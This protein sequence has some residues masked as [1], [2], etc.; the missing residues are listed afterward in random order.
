[1]ANKNYAIVFERGEQ[2]KEKGYS[3]RVLDYV[4][5]EEKILKGGKKV[6]IIDPNFKEKYIGVD[7]EKDPS[8]E[9]LFQDGRI[10]FMEDKN[11]LVSKYVYGS[12]V[13]MELFHEIIN[14]N[15]SMY[16]AGYE[17]DENDSK[18]TTEE[19]KDEYVEALKNYDFYQGV[20]STGR[21]K[22]Y[23]VRKEALNVFAKMD[24]VIGP[25][26]FDE[27]GM[28]IPEECQ[29]E[30]YKKIFKKLPESIDMKKI[31]DECRKYIIGQDEHILPVLCAIDDNLSATIPEEKTNVLV[32]GATGVGK[33]AVFKRIAEMV[34][35]PIVIENSTQFTKAGYVGRN[36][37]DIFEDLLQ[38]AGNDIELAQRG[39]IIIDEIDKKASGKDDRVSGIGVIHSMLKLLEGGQYTYETG[40]GSLSELKTFNTL[41][42]TIAFGGAFSGLAEQCVEKNI[43]FGKINSHKPSS[44]DIYSIDNLEKYGIPPE[45]VGRIQLIELFNTLGLEDLKKIMLE[46]LINPYNLFVEKMKRYATVVKSDESFIDAVAKEAYKRKTGARGLYSVMKDATKRAEGEIRLMPKYKKELILTPECVEDNSAYTLKRVYRKGTTK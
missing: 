4:E 10:M 44:I 32:G 18:K 15:N 30:N 12:P 42:T 26:V 11:S 31:Y 28:E 46:A 40:K 41:K 6:F 22:T 36:I 16:M 34:G 13:D 33:T 45:F 7:I 25:I 38:A 27:L 8:Y 35:L 9:Y 21:L 23:Y 1:M 17:P 2:D 24:D 19:M 37:D 29:E 14:Y 43:G 5:G 39:I 20:N 3:L